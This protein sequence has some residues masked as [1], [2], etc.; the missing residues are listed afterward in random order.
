M[1]FN[2]IN[3]TKTLSK[4]MFK[5]ASEGLSSFKERMEVFIKALK[6]LVLLD[7]QAQRSIFCNEKLLE[8]VAFFWVHG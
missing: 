2:S 1:F 3:F 5:G 6:P 8:D 4:V 7:N